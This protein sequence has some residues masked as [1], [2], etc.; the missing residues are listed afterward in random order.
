MSDPREAITGH[1]T[2]HGVR[3]DAVGRSTADLSEILSGMD[4]AAVLGM[5]PAR[6]AAIL[7]A[8]YAADQ[9]EERK[10]RSWW[11]AECIEHATAK[12]WKRPRAR[13]VEAL[14]YASI[15]EHMGYG[16]R[17]GTCQGTKERIVNNLPI[18]CPVCEGAGFLTYSPAIYA[19]RIGI[20]L[21]E[22]D[23]TWRT[24]VDWCRRRLFQWEQGAA[25]MFWDRLRDD[26]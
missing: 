18:T 26:G 14:A 21:L 11:L 4:Y 6:D 19:D 2:A 23:R 3:L 22:W 7:L 15:E 10:V 16:T 13:M 8:M 24:R 25:E 1:L 20:T 17:C 12:G 5:I 9:M